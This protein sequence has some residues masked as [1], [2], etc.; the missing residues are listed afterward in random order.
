MSGQLVANCVSGTL[1]Q[2]D[3][4]ILTSADEQAY[5]DLLQKKEESLLFVSLKYRNLLRQY[6]DAEDFYLLAKRG[7]D[8]VG[9]FPLFLK[10]NSTHGNVLNSLPFYGSN[11]GV[12]ISPSVTDPEAVF[13]A[14]TEGL[15]NLAR[16][17]DAV[18]VTVVTSPFELYPELY[19]E[20]LRPTFRDSRIGQVSHLPHS[21]E[22]P[23]HAVM[24][25]IHS[26]TRNMVR[27]ARKSRIA[28]RHSSDLEVLRFLADTHKENM[29]GIG[30][31][32]KG[33]E[34][35]RKVPEIFQYDT[36]YRVYAATRDGR[37]VSALLIFYHKK[38]VE[39]FTPATVR[40]YR[41]LQPNSLLIFEAMKDATR[42]KYH[43]WN[44]GGT[45][46]SQNG[47]RQFKN[48]WGA[49]DKPYYYYV[50]TYQD[51]GHIL[52]MKPEEIVVEYPFFYVV[53]FSA[54]RRA[55]GDGM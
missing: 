30:G 41:H 33:W 50:V 20:H 40:E 24:A 23:E 12:I 43:Y 5:E 39:Y 25:M 16:E 45:W 22:N 8:I 15:H 14:L 2:M 19:Q 48:R 11:G 13:K 36:D 26:K 42:Q 38:T 29:T 31:I 1:A 4:E 51:I 9:T 49:Q 34:F 18:A 7:G 46:H 32:A 54:L 52:N 44:F 27:K 37:P 6:I 53:P 17:T 47:V 55:K 21:G 10:K 35:F 28:H 3:I